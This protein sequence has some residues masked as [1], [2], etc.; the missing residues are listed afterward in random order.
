[1][2]KNQLQELAQRSCF[3]LPSYS[4]VRE[5]PDHAPRFKAKVTF[6]GEIFES[7][8]FCSNL[9]Q[10]EHAAAEVALRSLSQRGPSRAL[11]ARVLDETGI[12]KNLIQETAHRAGLKLPVYTTVRAGPAYAPVFTCTVELNGMTFAG[13]PA[14]TKKQAQKSAAMAAWF[15]LKNSA[16]QES[17]SSVSGLGRKDEQEQVTVARYLARLKLPE[18][19]KSA[20]NERCQVKQEYSPI[21]RDVTR[22]NTGRSFYEMQHHTFIYPN[23][24]PEV[25]IYPSWNQ[26]VFQ[27]QT[28][29]FLPF[30]PSVFRPETGLYSFARAQELASLVP[31]IRP[32][33]YFSNDI[34]PRPVG[35]NSQVTIEEIQ[36]NAQGEEGEETRVINEANCA[37]WRASCLSN[38]SLMP[39][40]ASN[41]CES[42]NN[43]P[44][45]RMEE[46]PR[47]KGEVE[48]GRSIHEIR[49]S[50]HPEAS[51]NA[52]YNRTS[53]EL[54][55]NRS[56]ETHTVE[57]GQR[58]SSCVRLPYNA[59]AS[60]S[61]PRGP[62]ARPPP[63]LS[64]GTSDGVF[65]T[66]FIPEGS[67]IS[68]PAST[69]R[70][71]VYPSLR[72]PLF[73]SMK[74]V[75]G[76]SHAGSMA[77][78]VQIRSVLPVCS[79]PPARENRTLGQEEKAEETDREISA[80]SS[81]FCR[82]QI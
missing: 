34:V 16:Q 82:L 24:L 45:L 62:L 36:E 2:Y 56:R 7:P 48:K 72:L 15:A 32:A 57:A 10:A 43:H 6:N 41:Y 55:H 8:S 17:C 54:I 81:E 50:D 67:T 60:S 19:R 68:L 49:N 39:T 64:A 66:R 47:E 33:F 5:G 65:S 18:T 80:A 20:R 74:N 9:R 69:P 63:T 46:F 58:L 22:Y 71:A 25:A 38:I 37:Q 44:S 21:R 42:F 31:E 53:S 26:Q 75:R 4:C 23:F 27:Q 28:L 59:M 12:Y 3:N 29:Q 77:P 51:Q 13:E 35:I 40:E 1:M 30:A 52:E 70:T 14:K 73:N 78:A 61:R 11:T 79:A 76:T